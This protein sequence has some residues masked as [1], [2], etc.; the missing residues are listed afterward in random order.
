MEIK[1]SSIDLLFLVVVPSF[2]E[3]LHTSRKEHMNPT[4]EEV[5]LHRKALE[6]WFDKNP[7]LTVDGVVVDPIIGE[8][9]WKPIHQHD[10]TIIDY[11]QSKISFPIKARPKKVVIH[12]EHY[13]LFPSWPMDGIDVLFA[14]DDEQIAIGLNADEPT[15]IW[16][17]PKLVSKK[18]ILP[19]PPPPPPRI[20]VPLLSVA[21]LMGLIVFLPLSF[22]LK[23]SL[24]VRWIGV[25]IL[26]M[27]AAGLKGQNVRSMRPF[28]LG[29]AKLPSEAEARDIFAVLQQNTYRAFDYDDE[30]KIFDVLAR[31]VDGKLLERLYSEIF[32]GLVLRQDGGAVCKVRKVEVL[33]ARITLPNDPEVREFKVRA[34]WRVTGRVGHYGHEHIRVTQYVADY[35]VAE[36][37]DGWRIAGVKVLNQRRLDPDD[38]KEEK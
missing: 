13:D 15:Y 20:N 6:D 16:H 38:L 35:V 3:W 24:R 2:D 18:A 37:D 11:V 7:L 29:D 31:S 36:R 23:L 27:A 34:K 10:G 33:S 32:E 28:W 21:C 26:V 17:A 12:W 22:L 30:E 8:M 25:L 4:P 1:E 19:D 9:K 5:Q 14:W